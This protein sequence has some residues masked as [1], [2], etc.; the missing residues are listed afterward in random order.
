MLAKDMHVSD[1]VAALGVSLFVWGYGIGPM[2]LS[3]LT[4]IS[5]VGRLWPYIFSI[6]IFVILQVPTVL[7]NNIGGYLVLRFLAGFL[8][9]PV[10]ATGGATMGDIW[11]VDGGFVI[12]IAFW[13]FSANGGPALGPLL[14]GFAV[15]HMGWRWSIW[16]LFWGIALVWTVTFLFFPET[17]ADTILTR[18]A[19][20]LRRVTKRKNIIS[21]GEKRDSR[22]TAASL[23]YDT[24]YRPVYL[25]VTEP[26]LLFSDL[27]IA[28]LYG[29]LYCFFEAFPLTFQGRHHLSV[30]KTGAAYISGWIGA[31][32]TLG[33]YILYNEKVVLKRFRSGNWRPEYRMEV[34]FAGGVL[35]PISMFWFGWT[36]F[37]SIHW[38]VPLLAFAMFQSAVYLLFQGF[39]GYIGENFPLCMLLRFNF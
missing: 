4:E 12:G 22:L 36:S 37:E 14:S 27:Y 24:L 10:L 16:P 25:T 30:G 8:G 17:S 39:L 26:V 13:G 31:A 2:I 35:F 32:I 5:F 28:Y 6:G 34:C 18:R 11:R 33:L 23:A 9:S 38:I 19:H 3:P 7:V 15:Q 20:S 21:A 29:I 1:T